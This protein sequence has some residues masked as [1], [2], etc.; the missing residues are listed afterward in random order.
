MA[1]TAKA[2]REERAPL[3]LK[4]KEMADLCEAENR[5]F[6]AEEQQNWETV[7][8]DYN[9]LTS[10]INRAEAAEKVVT[11]EPED[12][13]ADAEREIGRGDVSHKPAQLAT[14]SR[15]P[16]NEDL[17]NALQGWCRTSLDMPL[18]SRHLL[19][20]EKLNQNPR[21]KE[22]TLSLRHD[23][24]AMRREL[25]VQVGISEVGGGFLKPEGFVAN[26]ERALLAFGGVR[27]VADVM[28]TST[29]NDMPWPTSD[30][31]SNEATIIGESS[32]TTAPEQDA[33][34]GQ[35]IFRSH[36]YTS[37]LIR[38]STS[39]MQDSAFAMGNVVAEILGE[40]LGRGTSR[41]YTTGTGGSQ[42]QGIVTAATNGKTTASATAVTFDEIM[43][44]I[45]SVDPAYRGSAGFMMHD[46]IVL[47]IR[48]LKDGNGQY[49]WQ[50]S[51]QVGVPDRLLQYPI[52]INQH[53]QSSLA[54]AT[55]TMLFGD[56]SKYKIR[57]VADIRFRRLDERYA[58]LDQVGFVA[59]FRTDGALLNA[60][61]NPVKCMTQ[62]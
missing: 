38:V 60:G 41:H 31:T 1:K 32:P 37:K 52:T 48:K 58:E 50:Q 29:G 56:F 44:L 47:A 43:D 39:L 8:K 59:F 2:L 18:E 21:G 55:K 11:V 17:C 14:E 16:T 54:T 12:R 33:T 28:R 35:V 34:F 15:A 30:D 22:F 25:R 6:T 5:D 4:I 53:M 24:A 51:N 27:S 46:N 20:C 26:L 10:H 19:A 9:L 40:R 36:L 57:D 62:A 45:H 23:Y 61:T 42:P 7:N 13:K 3:A 49:L